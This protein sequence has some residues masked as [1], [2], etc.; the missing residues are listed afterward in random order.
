MT[1]ALTHICMGVPPEIVVWIYDTFDN[2]LEI[3]KN[4]TNYLKES[5]W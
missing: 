5:Y 2:K 3:D 1:L 4:F